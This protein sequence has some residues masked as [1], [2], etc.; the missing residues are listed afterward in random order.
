MAQPF[1]SIIIPAHNEA[2][3]LPLTLI[4]LDKY[5]SG[6]DF[7]YEVFVVNDGSD[8]AT[9]KIVESFSHTMKNLK[10]IH[11]EEHKGKGAAVRQGMLL[12]KGKLRA[13]IDADNSLD[14]QHIEEALPHFKSGAHVV[15][16]VRHR[17]SKIWPALPPHRQLVERLNNFIAGP[18]FF[19][20][21]KN[22]LTDAGSGF[23]VFSD[24]AVENIFPKAM[25]AGWGSDFEVLALAKSLGYEIK[26][27]PVFWTHDSSKQIPGKG[28]LQILADMAKIRWWLSRD[29]Y[30]IKNT[31]QEI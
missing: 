2:E 16:G 30:G 20:G 21:F 5:L 7:S 13:T 14:L 27:L 31:K 15:V 11:N 29:S 12:A 22:G 1:L 8:D 25:L 17:N 18:M 23:K 28:Y 24:E 9:A 19:G 4:D 3:R 10:L 6:R 26:E